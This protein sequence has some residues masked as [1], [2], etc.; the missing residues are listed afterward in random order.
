[1]M[2]LLACKFHDDGATDWRTAYCER[3]GRKVQS[4]Y[5]A[6]NI[7][8]DCYAWPLWWELGYWLKLFLAALGIVTCPS[9]MIQRLLAPIGKCCQKRAE[10]L[11]RGGDWLR[12]GLGHFVLWL[13]WLRAAIRRSDS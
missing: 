5:P 13:G 1:M 4:P 12:K 9:P 3:C 7:F 2:P 6:A 8:A 11:N 10:N